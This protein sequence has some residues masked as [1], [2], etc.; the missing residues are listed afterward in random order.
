MALEPEDGGVPDEP[1]GGGGG[2]GAAPGGSGCP[3]FGVGAADVVAAGA[4]PATP[5]APAD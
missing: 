2:A 1:V 3:I 5:A 4:T